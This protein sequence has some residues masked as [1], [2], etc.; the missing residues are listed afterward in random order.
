ME[1]WAFERWHFRFN[2]T[3]LR[4]RFDESRSIKDM[5]ILAQM[6]EDGEKY[7]FTNFH[8]AHVMSNFPGSAGENSIMTPPSSRMTPAVSATTVR[9]SPPTGCWT[10]GT[11]GRRCRWW[12][13][14]I[15]GKSSKRS[16]MNI[17]RS[18]WPRNTNLRLPLP[19]C[20]SPHSLINCSLVKI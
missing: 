14:S 20:N 2:A 6:L 8:K 13:T 7:V 17:M 18:L 10:S 3:V 5:R 4:A 9:P 12:T 15:R 11:P 16:S 1:S 19:W